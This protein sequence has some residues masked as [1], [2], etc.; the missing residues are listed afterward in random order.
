MYGWWGGEGLFPEYILL[1]FRSVEQIIVV[2]VGFE[3]MQSV[4]EPFDQGALGREG[5]L[6]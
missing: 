6:G 5:R 2:A 4:R 1:I 3:V